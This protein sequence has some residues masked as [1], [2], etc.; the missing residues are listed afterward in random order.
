MS[1]SYRQTFVERMIS[2]C[3]I[4]TSQKVLNIVHYTMNEFP[5][6]VIDRM[7]IHRV[8]MLKLNMKPFQLSTK[9]LFIHAYHPL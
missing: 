7:V 5:G 6:M 8:D 2:V 3:C 1:N 4:F 9:L